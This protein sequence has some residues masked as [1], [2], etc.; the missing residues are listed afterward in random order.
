MARFGS[1][2]LP[3]L[4]VFMGPSAF[5]A[6]LVRPAPGRLRLAGAERHELGGDHGKLH[7]RPGAQLGQ[8]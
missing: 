2:V 1:N 5:A 8:K 7:A 6:H 4:A 3:N